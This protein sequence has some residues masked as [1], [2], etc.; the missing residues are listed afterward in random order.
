MLRVV[1]TVCCVCV[2]CARNTAFLLVLCHL[3]VFCGPLPL[4]SPGAFGTFV[5][6]GYCPLYPCP[7]MLP[8]FEAL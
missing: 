5:P 4:G 8:D 6:P 3:P 7:G 2:A 1:L